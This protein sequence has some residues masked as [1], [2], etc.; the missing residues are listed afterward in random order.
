[1]KV[2]QIA[3]QDSETSRPIIYG[4]GDDGELYIWVDGKG[5]EDYK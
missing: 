4:L 2:I 1:M 3:I 5:W